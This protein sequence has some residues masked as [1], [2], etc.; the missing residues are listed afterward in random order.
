MAI[1]T[2]WTEKIKK[3]MKHLHT[4]LSLWSK[5]I[6]FNIETEKFFF[7]FCFSLHFHFMSFRSYCRCCWHLF[8]NF[9]YRETVF[10]KK[11]KKKKSNATTVNSEIIYLFCH[12]FV[13]FNVYAS[14]IVIV[15]LLVLIFPFC[16][17]TFL[18]GF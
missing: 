14:V 16:R 9:F 12:S 15:R 7:L 11:K 8:V 3:N 2:C 4:F 18:T 1:N 17:F 6:N 13:G 10:Q 5:T